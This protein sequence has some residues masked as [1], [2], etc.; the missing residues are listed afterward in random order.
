MTIMGHHT[1]AR[2]GTMHLVAANLWTWIRYVL[3]EESVMD[4][5]IRHIFTGHDYNETNHT[6]N[7]HEESREHTSE[8]SS[9]GVSELLHSETANRI[10]RSVKFDCSGGADCV[11]GSITD[12]M[13]TSIVEYSLIGAAIMF[14]VWKNIDHVRQTPTAYVKRKHQIR[15]DCSKTTSGLFCGLAFLAATF[16]SMA[17]F[18]G[19]SLIKRNQTAAFVFS[20]TDIV[21]VSFGIL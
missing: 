12:I 21:Q 14:I 2:F 4:K 18:Y 13:Y 20:I 19:Y 1:I 8:E 17:V 6:M 10:P 7:I 3:I 9:Y 15:V 16:T 11:L 5:E